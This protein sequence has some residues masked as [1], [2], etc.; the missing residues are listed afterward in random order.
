MDAAPDDPTTTPETVSAAAAEPA[1]S[2]D[3]PA[4]AAA[5]AIPAYRGPDRRAPAAR[6]PITAI[7]IIVL[8][9]TMGGALEGYA[10]A[11]A[12]GEDPARDQSLIWAVVGALLVVTAWATR[13]R[14]WWAVSGVIAIALVGTAIGVFGILSLATN[15]YPGESRLTVIGLVAV[16]AAAIPLFGLVSS[17]WEWLAHPTPRR[18]RQVRPHS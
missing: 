3:T 15:R 16:G 17:A 18:P 11:L 6:A 2:P 12:A 1:P 5:P 14:R 8:L 13:G 10:V 9:L 4:T 7:A